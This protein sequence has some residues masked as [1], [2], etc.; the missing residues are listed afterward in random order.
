MK[1]TSKNNLKNLFS[2][3]VVTSSVLG[4]AL[5]FLSA[6]SGGGAEIEENPVQAPPSSSNY[7]GPPPDTDDVQSFKLAVWDNLSSSNRCGQCHGV[8]QVPDFVN[9]D[10]INIAYAAANTI[11]DLSSPKDSRMVIKVGGG[12]LLAKQ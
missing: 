4:L 2:Q 10:D 9:L 5:I 7:A 11:A 1:I 3:P 8:G 6:C 12:Q